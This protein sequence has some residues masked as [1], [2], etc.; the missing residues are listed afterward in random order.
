MF[1]KIYSIKLWWIALFIVLATAS[2]FSFYRLSES[3]P[4]WYD[5]GIFFQAA[6]NM[7]NGD[8]HSIQI[9][10]NTF[11]PGQAITTG[12]TVTYPISLV[13]R[14]FGVSLL[15]AR[16]VMTLY[17][18]LTVVL[19]WRFLSE[20]AGSRVALYGAALL[21]SFAPL[22]GH[23]KSVMGEVPGVFFLLLFLYTLYR[24]E[25]AQSLPIYALSGLAAGLCVI[26]KPT[27]LIL[28]PVITVVGML[29]Y[30]RMGFSKLGF[31]WFF[32]SFTVPFVVWLFVQFSD[33]GSINELA[34]YLNPNSVSISEAVILN[35]KR[36]FSELQPAYFLS[37]LSIWGI[38]MFTRWRRSETPTMAECAAFG[39][40]L[41]TFLSFFR[42]SGYYRYFFP[43]Q[44]VALLFLPL[45]LF[46]FFG[47]FSH[48]PFKSPRSL[49]VVPHILLAGIIAFQFYQTSFH[50]WIAAYYNGTNSA[51]LEIFAKRLDASKTIFL[52]NVPEVAIFLPANFGY[53]QYLKISKDIII[54]K[55]ELRQIQ[56][57]VPDFIIMTN[58]YWSEHRDQFAGY[59]V[60]TT[61]LTRY[62]VLERTE[63]FNF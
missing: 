35:I 17:I 2:F 21:V 57:G 50:S 44:I 62:S 53:F 11:I 26:T 39:F 46:N 41:L 36:F 14:L 10:P 42:T 24:L 27:L 55:E 56:R 48:R 49:L 9:A 16:I 52:Y 28:L 47:I 18:L 12:L 61:D 37:L 45:S 31:L 58:L 29:L 5:E 6:V 43:G 13:F 59:T 60:T 40:S 15:S 8:G 63:K 32:I 34:H 33:T 23:G 25:K 22:Y 54:G 4:V 7:S 30:K 1:A 19:A 20:V 3:P 38:S 51:Q